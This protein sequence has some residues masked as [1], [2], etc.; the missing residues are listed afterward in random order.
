MTRRRILR[1]SQ[2]AARQVSEIAEWWQVNRAAATSLFVDELGSAYNLIRHQ[3]SA[4]QLVLGAKSD[5]VRRVHLRRSRYHL[6]YQESD[7]GDAIEI[8]AVW[9]TSRFGGPDL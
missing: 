1:L 7:N 5:R 6:Y 9:H 4:G 8:L 3:P 2:S